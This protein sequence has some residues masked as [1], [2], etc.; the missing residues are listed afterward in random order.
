MKASK[1]KANPAQVNEL[2]KSPAAVKQSGL[3]CHP[4]NPPP[5]K[6]LKR[7]HGTAAK[8]LRRSLRLARQFPEARLV[9][10]VFLAHL[11]HR[12]FV[13]RTVRLSSRLSWLA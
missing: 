11:L 12:L 5:P 8:T 1:G 3:A 2:M 13:V 10:R 7:R 9:R 6:N 4:A